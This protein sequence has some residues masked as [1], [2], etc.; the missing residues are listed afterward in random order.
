[1]KITFEEGCKW[2][3]TT[4]HSKAF[5]DSKTALLVCL[6]HF[7]PS[8]PIIVSA[9]CSKYGLGA[10]LCQLKDGVELPVVFASHTLNKAERN[11]SQTEKEALT[12]VFA[13]KK[14]H[15][16]WGMKFSLITDHKPLLGLFSPKKT[17]PKMVSGRIQRWA[18]M[19]QAYSFELYHRSCKYLG[20]ADTVSRLPLDSMPDSVVV[21]VEFVC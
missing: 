19:L 20:T 8:L 12:L 16:L 3:W 11:Y 13:L 2:N 1:M 5:Q 4:K 18:L 17:I 21:S 9:D 6:L 14:Y 10:V 15:Y 7:D